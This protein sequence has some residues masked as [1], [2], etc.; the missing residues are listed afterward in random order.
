MGAPSRLHRALV[1]QE[2]CAGTVQKAALERRF[3]YERRGGPVR[4]TKEAVQRLEAELVTLTEE[5]APRVRAMVEE[6]KGAGDNSQNPDY[7]LAAEEEA[8]L[9]ARIKR[10]RDALEAH[11]AASM[12]ALDT[13]TVQPGVFVDLDFGD[14]PESFYVGSI[15]AAGGDI[16]VLTPE[17]RVGAA[18]IGKRVGDVSDGVKVLSIRAES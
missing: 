18:L 10:V 13:E 12:V 1:A 16:T 2:A 14:G 9:L 6:A 17:S 11:A 4:L 7:F 8:N 3:L 15:S 5:E